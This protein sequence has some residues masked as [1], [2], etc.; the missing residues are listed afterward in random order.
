M[1][2]QTQYLPD[3][4]R[5]RYRPLIKIASK[6]T[7]AEPLSILSLNSNNLDTIS[8]VL[9]EKEY[10]LIFLDIEI[11]NFLQEKYD[12]TEDECNWVKR[13]AYGL[14]NGVS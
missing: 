1:I 3:L 10:S 14:L 5:N 7:P 8:T 12:L 11:E 2:G 13:M 4:N 6:S 9:I